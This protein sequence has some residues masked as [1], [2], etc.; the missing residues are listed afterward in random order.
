MDA[1]QKNKLIKFGIGFIVAL[2]V[3]FAISDDGEEEA[4]ESARRFSRMVNGEMNVARDTAEMKA[5]DRYEYRPDD[6]LARLE[7]YRR[8]LEKNAGDSR[9][10]SDELEQVN[11]EPQ[12]QHVIDDF[13][14][15]L[16][17]IKEINAGCDELRRQAEEVYNTTRREWE[18][19]AAEPDSE[20]EDLLRAEETCAK[21][22]EYKAEAEN[23]RSNCKSGWKEARATYNRLIK[24]LKI[25]VPQIVSQL[26][27]R[28]EE[29]EKAAASRA[30]VIGAG[31]T[32]DDTKPQMKAINDVMAAI[33]TCQG[34]SAEVVLPALKPEPKPLPPPEFK[35]D[36]VLTATGDLPEALLRPLVVRWL[37]AKK[38]SPCKGDRFIWDIRKGNMELEV[39]APAA[40]QGAESGKLRIRIVPMNTAAAA[41]ESIG[42]QGSAHLMLTGAL[43]SKGTVEAQAG[44][45]AGQQEP[46]R[47]F[48]ARICYDAL[49]FFG[50]SALK[51][52]PPLRASVM[53]NQ[54]TVFSVNDA[55]RTEAVQVFGL[56]PHDHD[57]AEEEVLSCGELRDMYADKMILGVWHKDAAGA[58]S[59]SKMPAIGYAAGWE[60]EEAFRHV[61]E[62]YLPAT[63]GVEPTPENIA[64]GRYAYSYSIYGYRSERDVSSTASAL[65]ADLLAFIADAENARVAQVIRDAGFVPVELGMDNSVR[66]NQLTRDDLPIPVLLKAMEGDAEKFGYDADESEWVYGVRVPFA[67]YFRTGSSEGDESW[68]TLDADTAYYTSTQA[69]ARIQELVQGERAAVVVVGHADIQHKG[70]LKVDASSWRTNLALSQKRADFVGDVLRKKFPT[71]KMLRHVAIGTGWARPSC[72]ISL[73]ENADTQENELARCRRAEVFIIFPVPGSGE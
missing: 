8:R 72:D 49:V 57:V 59:L 23:R 15:K 62:E 20:P 32:V 40:L 29:R 63:A 69:F 68:L 60:S 73:T 56:T 24:R 46:G 11:D 43:P 38:A 10:M 37:E 13:N 65:A 55:A 54:P 30:A 58:M 34:G 64:T 36:M 2:V 42:R 12:L 67:M 26:T 61:P 4:R 1:K 31:N 21:L 18:A 6:L 9:A 51:L 41:F 17:Q 45:S 33:R 16:L 48:K 66:S 39:Y 7:G 52:T 50:G 14:N 47:E 27:L 25:K 19:K 22:T 44:G 28:R 5:E 3:A 35:P 53:K 71:G 70:A